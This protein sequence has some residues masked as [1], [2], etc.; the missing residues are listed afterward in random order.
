MT[1]FLERP[2]N[3]V[4]W[5]WK[6]RFQPQEMVVRVCRNWTAVDLM[7]GTK[8]GGE[9]PFFK[10]RILPATDGKFMEKTAY[11]MMDGSWDLDFGLMQ[12][13]HVLLKEEK[14]NAD[15]LDRYV[16]VHQDRGGWLAWKFGSD[17]VTT[18]VGLEFRKAMEEAESA[19]EVDGKSSR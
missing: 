5:R 17:I 1:F 11:L 9:S 8:K 6:V 2:A 14:L 4:T 19:S 10:T 16:L 18:D 7:E 15:D 3:P 12:D 13:A